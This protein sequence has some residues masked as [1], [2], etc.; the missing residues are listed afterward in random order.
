MNPLKSKSF[1]ALSLSVIFLTSVL[2][3]IYFAYFKFFERTTD[4]YITGNI[5]HLNSQI[6]GHVKSVFVDD[7]YQ[8]KQG[9]LLVSLDQSDAILEVEKS[10]ATLADEVRFVC[11]LIQEIKQ[12]QSLIEAKKANVTRA[13]YDYCNRKQVA[14]LGSISKEEFEHAQTTLAYATAELLAE[15]FRLKILQAKLMDSSPENHPR[16]EMA[17]TKLKEAL[18][19]Q[20]RCQIYAPCD[21][22]VSQRSVQVGKTIIPEE[23]LLSIVPLDQIWLI[24]NFKETQL[25]YLRNGQSVEFTS[26]MWGKEIKFFGQIVGQNPGSG[27][28]FA[29]IPPQNATGNWIKIVQRVPVKIDFDVSQLQKHPL[30][31]GLSCE[32]KV[33]I[34]NQ[35]LDI[36]S[37]T[38]EKTNPFHTDI[39]DSMLGGFDEQI[40]AVILKNMS[41]P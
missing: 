2:L 16:V 41:P 4:A 13:N 38:C 21:G 6:S 22:I 26:D 31:L 12:T 15:K 36:I 10:K 8:V 17:K 30:W 28:V 9:Q 5:I 32:V 3:F 25:K 19:K 14:I 40:N 27:A 20:R 33:D 18:L 1:W 23:T 24:A 29:P 11:S 35:N 37:K 34:R 39:Y 7:T